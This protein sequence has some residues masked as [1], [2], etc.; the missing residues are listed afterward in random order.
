MDLRGELKTWR[1]WSLPQPSGEEISEPARQ[2][3]ELFE[4]AVRLRMRSDVPVGV[5]LSG[6]LD[7]TAIICAMARQWNG[8]DAAIARFFL[9][10]DRNST[11]PRYIADTIELT[12]AHLNRLETDPLQAWQALDQVLSFHDEPVHAMA[13]VIGF[14]LMS[15][16]ASKGVKVIL[17]GQGADEVIGGYS[18]YFEDYWY[19]LMKQRQAARGVERDRHLYLVSRR[20]QR[21]TV[22]GARSAILPGCTREPGGCLPASGSLEEPRAARRPDPWFSSELSG[23]VRSTASRERT[24]RWTPS[25]ANRSSARPFRST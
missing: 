16:A 19:T 11:N 20:Q 10:C 12:R 7:S 6:G 13:A 23:H 5:C 15:L 14:E 24:G 2:F 8:S 21:K 4:D 18:S 25:S 22:L 1:Y 17:N 9:L 3:A